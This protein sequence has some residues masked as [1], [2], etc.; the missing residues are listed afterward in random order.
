MLDASKCRVLLK[1]E[2]RVVCPSR[3]EGSDMKARKMTSEEKFAIVMPGLKG[4]KSAS[5]I[6]R[7]NGLSHTMQYQVV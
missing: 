4:E 5:E 6:C 2:E 7:E 3:C 1:G